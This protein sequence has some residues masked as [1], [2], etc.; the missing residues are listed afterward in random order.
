[1]TSWIDQVLIN[2]ATKDFSDETFEEYCNRMDNKSGRSK[3][4]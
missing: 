2:M 3:E 4:C 1:M